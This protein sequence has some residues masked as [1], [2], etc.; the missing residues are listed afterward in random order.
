MQHVYHELTGKPFASVLELGTGGGFITQQFHINDLDF[1]AIE[2]SD[3]GIKKLHN[4]GIKKEMTKK[5]DLRIMKPLKKSFDL[6]MCTEVI[7]HIE[8]FFASSIVELCTAHSNYIW[9]SCAD[10]KRKPHWHHI[11]EISIEAWDNLFAFYGF[12]SFVKLNGLHSRADR[13]YMRTV[14]EKPI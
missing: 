10:R 5:A 3:E 13:L 6:V 4:I 7:E 1:F 12:N 14:P 11:N 2:G 8:P 9:F